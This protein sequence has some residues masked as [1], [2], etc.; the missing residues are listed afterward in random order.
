L[1]GIN[2]QLVADQRTFL[3]HFLQR[4]D[5][6]GMAEG[7]EIRVPLL[8]LSLVEYANGLPGEAKVAAG[9]TKLCLKVAAEGI[10]PPEARARP[11]Q[12]F[13]MPMAPLLREGPLAGLLDDVLLERPRLAEILDGKGVAGVVRDFRAGQEELWKVVWLLLATELWMRAFRAAP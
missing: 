5:R 1:D 13:E 10:L 11:K 3:Q 7:V 2:R 8:D 9:G 4:S 12:P 6:M